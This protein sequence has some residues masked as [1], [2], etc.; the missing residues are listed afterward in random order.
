MKTFF[1]KKGFASSL[2]LTCRCGY[3]KLFCTSKPC[4][5]S[6]DINHR[7]VYTMRSIGQGYASIQKFTS[8]MDLRTPMTQ[9][10]CNSTVKTIADVVQDVA[11][12]TINETVSD[13]K[14]N[15]ILNVGVSCD[16]SWQR[17][18]LSSLNGNFT[19]ISLD[20]GKVLDKDIMT[21]YRKACKSKVQ[22]KS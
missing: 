13:L 15:D 7:I 11:E 17:R 14:E 9:K 12:E 21:R 10:S 4:N 6:F 2:L 22:R 19:T 3:I 8:L 16:G 1:L 20:N 5:R 18:S